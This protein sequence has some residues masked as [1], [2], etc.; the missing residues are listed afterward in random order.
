MEDYVQSHR[1]GSVSFP[2]ASEI[3]FY[4]LNDAPL[5]STATAATN[6]SWAE[7][8]V[9]AFPFYNMVIGK[10][11]TTQMSQSLTRGYLLFSW[12]QEIVWL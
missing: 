4:V 7:G 9:E 8:I 2:H 3:H 5:L 12:Y 6:I 10:T 1:G 11:D